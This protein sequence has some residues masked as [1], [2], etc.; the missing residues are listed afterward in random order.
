MTKNVVQQIRRSATTT[1]GF[2]T[3]R[4]HRFRGQDNR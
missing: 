1:F 2:C 4:I 3:R